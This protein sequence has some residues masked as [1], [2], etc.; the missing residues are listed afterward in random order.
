MGDSELTHWFSFLESCAKP[1]SLVEQPSLSVCLCLIVFGVKRRHI[2][3]R[4]WP[5]CVFSLAEERSWAGSPLVVCWPWALTLDLTLSPVGQNRRF[6]FEHLP[7]TCHAFS[8]INRKGA[9]AIFRRD[10]FIKSS[11]TCLFGSFQLDYSFPV[12]SREKNLVRCGPTHGSHHG[13]LWQG[14]EPLE[15]GLE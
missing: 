10:L 8:F 3:P 6:G 15:Q 14:P 2:L 9:S 12:F 1:L 5:F 4:V 13:C 11:S 7:T